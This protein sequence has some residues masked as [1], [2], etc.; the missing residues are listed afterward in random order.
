MR[1]GVVVG[2]LVAG[3][4]TAFMVR[5]S[6]DAVLDERAEGGERR[7]AGPARRNARM[8]GA[9]GVGMVG[10]GPA[11]PPLPLPSRVITRPTGNP[12]DAGAVTGRV[13]SGG[14][15]TAVPGAQLL[16]AGEDGP[17]SIGT[18]R[19]GRFHFAPGVPGT[20][21][22]IRVTA[23]GFLPFAAPTGGGAPALRVR[24]GT[25]VD[26]LRMVLT[27]RE[28]VVVRVV[29][30]D[31]A[32]P[33]AG[34]TLR[35]RPGALSDPDPIEDD[36]AEGTGQVATDA[37]GRGTLFVAEG[38]VIEA[39]HPTLG[40]GRARVDLA[41]RLTGQLTIALSGGEDAP[42]RAPLAGRVFNAEGAP[43][44]GCTV[45]AEPDPAN[46]AHPASRLLAPASGETRADGSFR[47]MVD[48]GG[49]YAV[50]ARGAGG[51]SPRR[52][53]VRAPVVDLALTLGEHVVLEGQ[54]T[55]AADGEP[56][57]SF[58]VVVATVRGAVERDVVAAEVR[59]DPDG[60]FRIP[61]LAPG[62]RLVSVFADGYAPTLERA[63]A[64]SPPT[65]RI[66]IALRPGGAIRGRLTDASD[67][68]PIA[69]GRV[70][71][72]GGA[73]TAPSPLRST[74]VSDRDGR[75]VLTGVGDGPRSLFASAGGYHARAVGGVSPGGTTD[76]EVEIALT[77]LADGETPQVELV[78]IGAVLSAKDD[79]LVVGDVVQGGGAAAVG[80]EPGDAIVSVDGV[81][82]GEMG[83]A[84][85][86]QRI[87]GPEGSVVRLRVRRVGMAPDGAIRVVVPRR[88]LRAR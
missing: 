58:A 80:L 71:L 39:W 42:G 57:P 12:R 20:W 48:D 46:P 44:A 55:S 38:A 21:R 84:T 43:V 28:P 52:Y 30:G 32:T 18:D 3:S 7:S 13:V 35:A 2:A 75:F 86:V 88:R 64:L 70:E 54:V 79:A 33:V 82:V 16:L 22:L 14:D 60:R 66:T 19:E 53:R 25:D 47:L 73:A 15:G 45:L 65:A 23:P 6:R 27:P 31:E 87:R 9:G 68:S 37:D 50:Q 41:A 63:L 67:G 40:G 51:V 24:R 61:G 83:F 69:G 4:G 77:P 1:F 74:A 34:A 78:G 62:E 26:G 81:P 8:R 17:A 36:G 11:A 59:V 76:P 10:G 5:S 72:E 56:V 49:T 29:Q 85:A